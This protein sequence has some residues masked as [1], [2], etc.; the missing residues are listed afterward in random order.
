MMRKFFQDNDGAQEVNIVGFVMK[1]S[2]QKPTTTEKLI[3]E[4]LV[5]IFGDGIHENV[6]YFLTF[7]DNNEEPPLLG[8]FTGSGLP[9]PSKFRE[10][11]QGQHPSF[12][13][14]SL[15]FFSWNKSL[16]HQRLEGT[17]GTE[18]DLKRADP[19]NLNHFLWSMTVEN[20]C[21]FFDVYGDSKPTSISMIQN[22]LKEKL[23]LK[24]TVEALDS[25]IKVDLAMMEILLAIQH[26]VT[27]QK[28]KIDDGV[29]LMIPLKGMKK[30]FIIELAFGEHLATNCS[31]C[32]TTCHHS[33]GCYLNKVAQCDV[34]DHSMPIA[35]RCCQVLVVCRVC[36]PASHLNGNLS[37]LHVNLQRAQ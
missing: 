18:N 2:L 28:A 8:N 29:N 33:C 37:S 13:F 6:N 31:K 15:A 10:T 26:I 22:L 14:N 24:S 34:M 27:N 30:K 35:T 5:S 17:H 25:H 36:T 7:A 16:P 3:Y 4:S 1:S 11:E 19:C 21:F 23:R 9:L 12:Q 32:D 20:F